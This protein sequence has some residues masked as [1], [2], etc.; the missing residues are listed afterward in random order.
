MLTYNKVVPASQRESAVERMYRFICSWIEAYTRHT[1]GLK[2][3]FFSTIF[4]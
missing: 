2:R 1:G 3:C 4:I